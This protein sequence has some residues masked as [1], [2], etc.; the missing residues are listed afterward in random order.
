MTYDIVCGK[1]PDVLASTCAGHRLNL[2]VVVRQ[3]AEQFLAKDSWLL[4]LELLQYHDLISEGSLVAGVGWK[5]SDGVSDK[6]VDVADRL[7]GHIV[8]RLVVAGLDGLELLL[9]EELPRV[10]SA[11]S[12]ETPSSSPLHSRK[13]MNGN[14]LLRTSWMQYVN[15][16]TYLVYVYAFVNC[17]QFRI[18]AFP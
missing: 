4:R 8:R 16:C 14:C 1:N 15:V 12:A 10:G 9:E 7:G 5:T 6:P 11:A 13:K 3:G 2:L 17:I 18:H